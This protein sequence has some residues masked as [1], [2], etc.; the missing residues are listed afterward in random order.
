MAKNY[1][2]KYLNMQK[3]DN[4][5]NL[6]ILTDEACNFKFYEACGCEKVYETIVKNKEYGK[7]GNIPK[8]KA[9]I[10]EKKL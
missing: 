4:M 3:K 2:L 7:L 8:S 10:Y 1:C 5:R 6:Q 9:F